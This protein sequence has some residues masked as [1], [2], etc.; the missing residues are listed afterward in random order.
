[1]IR[2]L[3]KSEPVKLIAKR[4]ISS[5]TTGGYRAKYP[6]S[7]NDTPRLEKCLNSVQL[8][9]RVGSEPKIGGSSSKKVVQFSMATSIYYGGLP[10]TGNYS[11]KSAP[12]QSKTLW[13]NISVFRPYLQEKVENNVRKGSRVLVNGSL[14]YST[15]VDEQGIQKTNVSII[16][17]EIIILA[18]PSQE[19]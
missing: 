12:T 5:Q 11:M 7:D 8:L 10:S 19:N 17:D 13:H 18:T 15:Y 4:T 14:D 1:M 3:I 9:G 6:S 16:P 2:N